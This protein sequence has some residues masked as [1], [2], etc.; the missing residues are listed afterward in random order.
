[1]NRPRKL[2]PMCASVVMAAAAAMTA[3]APAAAQDTV[4]QGQAAAASR[5]LAAIRQAAQSGRYLFIFF[6]KENDEQ[7]QKMLAVFGSAIE[8]FGEAADSV[9]I[10]ITDP[11]ER[12][13]VQRFGV[14]R[15]PMP[16]VLAIAPC[17]AVTKGFPIQFTA[18]DLRQAFVSPCTARCMKALQDR[19]LVVLCVASQRTPHAQAALQGARDFRAD[20]RFASATEVVTLNPNDPAETGF[21]RQLQ[22][23][24]RSPQATT[25]LLAPPGQPI[26]RFSGAVTKDQIVAKVASAKSGPCANG[27]CGPGGCGPRK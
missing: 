24:P 7:S 23:D 21:L 18:D 10:P 14:S 4:R 26:A 12:P 3:I 8:S 6:W 19:K 17:G 11:A 13:V 16:L 25:V 15:A 22:V 20:A 1:M 27:Q 5:G 9:G 2:A